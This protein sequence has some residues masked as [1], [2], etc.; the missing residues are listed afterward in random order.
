MALKFSSL[1]RAIGQ[2]LGSPYIT[3]VQ[4]Y[5]AATQAGYI[6]VRQ[7]ERPRTLLVIRNLD[8]INSIQV[9]FSVPGLTNVYRSAPPWTI[10][11]NPYEEYYETNTGTQFYIRPAVDNAAA[12]VEVETII[13]VQ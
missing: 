12:K 6:R 5:Q 2:P 3:S 13:Q 7:T 9:G 10:T 8:E 11:L 1:L 4:Y